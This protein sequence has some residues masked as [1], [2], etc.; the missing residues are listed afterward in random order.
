M[1]D[2]FRFPHTAHLAWLGEGEPRDDKVLPS[3]EATA[4]LDADVV[5][6]E[7]VDG[8]NLGFSL[9]PVGDLRAQNR[10][11]YLQTPFGG[12]FVRLPAWLTIH[13]EIIRSE[14]LSYSNSNLLLFGEWC[15]ARHS[16]KYEHLPDWFLL[17]D[18]YERASNVFWSS[19]R[20]DALALRLG[21][22]TV[23][24]LGYG[25]FTLKQLKS[26]LS[27]SPSRFRDGALEGIVIRRESLTEC[28]QRAKL[29][30]AG[31]T[32]GVADHWRSRLIEW[33]RV[34]FDREGS[35]KP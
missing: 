8:A 23:P 12:Q 14:L 29:V 18:V 27:D 10:G 31:F 28:V 21:L 4:L 24:R 25:R 32:Q 3:S 35:Y 2:F 19:A 7:K 15:A 22:A 33:N 17:F 5:I 16:L 13:E 9:S 6:E 11:Q 30:R 34:D 1:T 26:V 20:R